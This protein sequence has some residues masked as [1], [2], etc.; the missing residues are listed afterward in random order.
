MQV[1][2]M[3][4]KHNINIYGI[5]YIAALYICSLKHDILVDTQVSSDLNILVII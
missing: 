5:Y 4:A 2:W 3:F 1:Y